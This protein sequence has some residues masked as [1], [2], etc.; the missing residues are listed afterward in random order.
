MDRVRGMQ[1][2]TPPKEIV[3]AVSNQFTEEK[4]IK[5]ISQMI[6]GYINLLKT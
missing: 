4:E 6:K 3:K 2:D 5:F 1:N